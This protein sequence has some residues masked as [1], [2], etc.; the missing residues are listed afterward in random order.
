MPNPQWPA[1]LPQAFLASNFEESFA[2]T[3][4]RI[5]MDAGPAYVISR[6]SAAEVPVT[7]TMQMSAAQVETLAD[8]HKTTLAGGALRFDFPR[9]R[10][11]ALVAVRMVKPP[12]VRGKPGAASLYLV[13]LQ[14]EVMP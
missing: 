12:V 5:E 10:S 9:P 3:T 13:A 7:G 14:L 4:E 6:F 11:G 8:F 1:S 2:D